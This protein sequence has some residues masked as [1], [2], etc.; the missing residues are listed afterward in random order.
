MNV[1]IQRISLIKF[2]RTGKQ[3]QKLNHFRTS[4][5]VQGS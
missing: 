1:Y 3:Q 5:V 4:L 2:L